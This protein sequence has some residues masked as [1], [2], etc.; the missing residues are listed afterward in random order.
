MLKQKE[1]LIESH[2]AQNQLCFSSSMFPSLCLFRGKMLEQIYDGM[3]RRGAQDHR[4]R[5]S[6]WFII[7]MSFDNIKDFEIQ[8]E[9]CAQMEHFFQTLKLYL[10]RHKRKIFSFTHEYGTL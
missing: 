5:A 1:I 2:W 10:K 4:W 7:Q 6:G 8:W 9:F 3:V